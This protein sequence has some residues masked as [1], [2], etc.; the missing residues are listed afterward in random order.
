MQ[1]FIEFYSNFI[2]KYFYSLYGFIYNEIFIHILLIL[3]KFNTQYAIL[4]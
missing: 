3:S 1:Y 4:N 2:K